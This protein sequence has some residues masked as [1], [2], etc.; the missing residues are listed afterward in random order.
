M[1]ATEAR[2]GASDAAEAETGSRRGGE[3]SGATRV[4]GVWRGVGEE[5]EETASVIRD[6]DI[7]KETA[8]DY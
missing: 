4:R 6:R 2:S 1:D 7:A 5:G 3:G 8:R